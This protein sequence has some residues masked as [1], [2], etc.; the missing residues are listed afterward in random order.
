MDRQMWAFRGLTHLNLGAALA[1]VLWMAHTELAPVVSS[2]SRD[3]AG[4]PSA[5]VFDAF[6]DLRV[7]A[8]RPEGRRS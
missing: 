8:V 6:P 5:V 2:A 4:K 1:L 7:Q 3:L